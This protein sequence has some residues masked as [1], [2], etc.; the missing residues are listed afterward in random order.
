MSESAKDWNGSTFGELF[1]EGEERG[2]SDLPLLA[3]TG[4]R[5]VVFRDELERRDTSPVDKSKYKVVRAG[6]IAYNTMRLWQGVLGCSK[7]DGIVSPAY[8]V[9]RPTSGVN[10]EYFG[11]LMK[12]PW[13][14]QRFLQR[15][16]GICD[17]TNN[18]KYSA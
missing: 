7:Y 6:D 5:G 13:M 2:G 10:S 14:I 8:T 4:T 12:T 16:Q 3:V 18:C 9:L 1:R 11:Y 15:S 17:D